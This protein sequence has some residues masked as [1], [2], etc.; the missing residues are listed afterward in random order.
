MAPQR[1]SIESQVLA[2]LRRKFGREIRPE[3]VW[4]AMGTSTELYL[5]GLWALE[6]RFKITFTEAEQKGISLVSDLI[7][8]VEEK[9]IS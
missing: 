2:E 3:M 7:R 8:L 5:L 9:V 4:R 6:D 1:S